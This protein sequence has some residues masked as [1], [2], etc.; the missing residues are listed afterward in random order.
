MNDERDDCGL[1]LSGGAGSDI[2]ERGIDELCA[3]SRLYCA[4]DV[5]SRYRRKRASNVGLLAPNLVF[6]QL[7]P[8]RKS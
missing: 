2:A 1:V 3:L 4:E 8:K 5:V 6:L 7:S